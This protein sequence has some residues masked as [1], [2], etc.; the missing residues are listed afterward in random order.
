MVRRLKVAEA[1]AI[2]GVHPSFLRFCMRADRL[3]FGYCIKTS[4]EHTYYINA[5]Q[6]CNY[7]GISMEKLE[8]MLK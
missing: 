4:S 6:F 7:I 5:T 3:P 8:E 2:M 1:S